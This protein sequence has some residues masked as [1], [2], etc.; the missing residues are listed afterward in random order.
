[1]NKISIDLNI[2]QRGLKGTDWTP[3]SGVITKEKLNEVKDQRTDNT[4]SQNALPTPFAR[5]FLMED[6]F[7]LVTDEKKEGVSVGMSYRRM[8]S[9]CLD[10]YELL[11]N[12]QYNINHWQ[13]EGYKLKFYI[14]DEKAFSSLK[15][16]VPLLAEPLENY[17]DN[18]IA[19]ERK[20]IFL[21]LVNGDNEFLLACSSPKTGWVT[22]PDLDKKGLR[23]GGLRP[24]FVGERYNSNLFPRIKRSHGERGCY[25]ND[26]CLF[27]E[28]AA[29]FKNYMLHH[30]MGSENC[31]A[32]FSSIRSYINAFQDS[33]DDIKT[34]RSYSFKGKPIVMDNGERLSLYGLPIT[35]N[36]GKD[37]T[38][39]FTDD[40]I[41]LPFGIAREN[42]MTFVPNEDSTIGIDHDYLLPL[43]EEALEVLALE[44]LQISIQE[45]SRAD[46]VTVT[47]NHQGEIYKK[48]YSIDPR[49][50]EGGLLDLSLMNLNLDIALFPNILSTNDSNN[51]YFKIAL[52]AKDSN[53]NTTLDMEKTNIKFFKNSENG[54]KHIAEAD[55]KEWEMGMKTSIIRSNQCEQS[56]YSSKY[57]ELFNTTFDA[58][59]LHL[60]FDERFFTGVI[61]PR[62]HHAL[63]TN[64]H[65]TYA[66]DF[67][68]TNTY[69]S[70]REAGEANVPEQLHMQETMTSYLH[71]KEDTL[72]KSLVNRW[73]YMPFTEAAEA[74]QTE[75][76]PVFIDGVKYRFPIRTAMSQRMKAVEELNLFGNTN[77]NFMYEKALP[78]GENYVRTNIKWDAKDED[79]RLF[80]RE[81]LMIIRTDLLQLGGDMRHTNIVW[82]RPLSF[83]PSQKEAYERIWAEETSRIL[84]IPTDQVHCYTE[85][86]APYYYYHEKRTFAENRSVVLIDIGG[87]STDMVHFSGN[88]LTMANSVHFGCDTLWSGGFNRMVNDHTSNGVY[89]YFKDKIAF[90]D[91]TLRLMNE[92]MCQPQSRYATN[93][94]INFWIS[95]DAESH[96][97]DGLRASFKPLFLYHYV[98]VIF[99]MAQLLRSRGLE[100]PTAITFSGNGSRY[101]DEYLTRNVSL[102]QEIT[103]MILGRVMDN[104]PDNIQLVMPQ[105][106]KESTCYGGL[107]KTESSQSPDPYFMIGTDKRQYAD[108]KEIQKDYESGLLKH[109]LEKWLKEVAVIYKQALDMLIKREQLS[110]IDTKSI[111]S[112][113]NESLSIDTIMRN[114]V[115]DKAFFNDALFFLPITEII[116]KLT[117]LN[118][119]APKGSI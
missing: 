65:Y 8:V 17:F 86:E 31:P 117:H 69:I 72:Q 24:Q 92:Q 80:I 83:R 90:K 50:D 109:G 76:L 105:E 85:S 1:M 104:V 77:I 30:L 112:I 25:F 103:M 79:D 116:R 62:F 22:P 43:T 101:I 52:V 13:N 110:E 38:N 59:M 70:R 108:V 20:L 45:N 34:G 16:H 57:F 87:G 21:M 61:L 11:Y 35:C 107:Y 54:F 7:R 42:F 12:W 39:F 102:L 6:A 55:E 41:K 84:D 29:G 64:K 48:I 56:N 44:D 97:T 93:D 67:G 89:N 4:S 98:S 100:C 49:T 5:F 60:Y 2:C 119:K 3:E 40:I 73:E 33:S 106:R 68:T 78:H 113:V 66:I 46:R 95:N 9:D 51:N 63:Q 71:E 32:T 94:I 115:F 15:K 91:E 111:N 75:F 53:K 36:D 37:A 81:L 82:F 96:V 118:V 14:W 23:D 10:V 74:W 47:L 18:D 99:Y 26:C 27:E 28:R 58:M 88:K 19:K 114:E